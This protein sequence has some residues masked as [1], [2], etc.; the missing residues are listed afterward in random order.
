MVR[1]VIRS[2]LWVPCACGVRAKGQEEL[3]SG[4]HAGER[5]SLVKAT[6]GRGTVTCV[7]ARPCT[8]R[9]TSAKRNRSAFECKPSPVCKVGGKE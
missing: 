8:P 9:S 5:A 2:S 1:G 7:S 3:G 4:E 6:A